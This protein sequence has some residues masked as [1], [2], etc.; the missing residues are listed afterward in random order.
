[1]IN[2]ECRGRSLGRGLER[3]FWPDFVRDGIV[4]GTHADNETFEIMTGGCG[5]E[6]R[7]DKVSNLT[8]FARGKG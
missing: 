2:L 5:L 8:I 1:M 6:R 4:L 7:E 3:E